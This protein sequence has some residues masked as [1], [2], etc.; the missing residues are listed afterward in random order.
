MKQIFSNNQEIGLV[1]FLEDVAIICAECGV[2][3]KHKFR[4]EE[5]GYS[6]EL[7]IAIPAT[8]ELQS[9]P[10][11]TLIRLDCKFNILSP[12]GKDG[13]WVIRIVPDNEGRFCFQ[14]WSFKYVCNN[15]ADRSGNRYCFGVL[16]TSNGM[17]Y[18][19]NMGTCIPKLQVLRFCIEKSQI[20]SMTYDQYKE[21]ASFEPFR[22]LGGNTEFISVRT[23]KEVNELYE[24]EKAKGGDIIFYY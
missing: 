13:N 3:I 6:Y 21:D 17:R 16:R 22:K 12:I 20:K 1:H 2:F 18:I 15:I 10:L 23:K 4:H 11:W 5:P 19:Y 8:I 9:I 7:M 24:K 14:N